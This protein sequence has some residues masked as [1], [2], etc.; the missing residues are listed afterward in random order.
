MR[1]CL[2]LAQ[3]LPSTGVF[4]PKGAGGSLAELVTLPSPPLE[5]VQAQGVTDK[6]LLPSSNISQPP[7]PT[8]FKS[9]FGLNFLRKPA[10][11]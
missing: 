7:P 1:V 4:G 5:F 9:D 2:P 11:C 6:D 8:L 10:V 3:G